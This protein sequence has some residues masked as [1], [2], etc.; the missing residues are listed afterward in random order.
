MRQKIY[1]AS[2]FHLGIPDHDS[3]LIR[4]KKLIAWLDLA[5]YD[6]AE[7][8]LMGDLFDFWFEYKTAIPRGYARLLG[9]LA[10]ITDAGILVHL[11]RGNHDMWAFDYLTSEIGILLHRNPEFHEFHGR[12][13][14]LA[15]GDGLGPGDRGYKFI[16]RVFANRV[17]QWLFRQLHPDIGIR[18][19]LFWSRKSRNANLGKEKIHQDLN[20]KLI[21]ERITVHSLELL[22]Q[23]P[24]L[25]YLIYGHY[26]CPLD[27][28][29]T[30]KA[31]QLV[32]GDWITHFTYAVFD[33]ESLELKVFY[34]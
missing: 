31:R 17:N 16:K 28:P 10:E 5:Q 26:H 20:L 12:H 27:A 11:F 22:K 18:L 23:H 19:A 25:D 29:L 13:F 6:A 8:F 24:E 4:E 1:F 30:D 3:S 2:D 33:G 7:I 9:K 14:Y 15:H 21:R 34:P 32:L